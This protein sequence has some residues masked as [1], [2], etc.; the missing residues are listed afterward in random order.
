M[1]RQTNVGEGIIFAAIVSQ[2]LPKYAHYF[3]PTF[4]EVSIAKIE[5][6]SLNLLKRH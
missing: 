6:A 4:L 5:Q 3:V 2:V 1:E